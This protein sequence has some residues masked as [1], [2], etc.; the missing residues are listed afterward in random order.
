MASTIVKSPP[1][2]PETSFA[3]I[4]REQTAYADH[5][6]PDAIG[7]RINGWFDRLMIQTGWGVLP[8]AILALCLICGVALGGAAFVWKENFL[9]AALGALIGFVLPMGIAVVA[10]NRRQ[11]KINDQ[12][13]GMIDE[14][15]RAARTGRSLE[16]CLDMVAK[17]TPDPLGSEMSL[18]TKA[19]KL[20]LPVQ[21]AMT[22]LPER[23]GVVGTSILTTALAVHSQTGGD[24][25]HVLERLSRTLR[26]RQELLGRLRAATTASRLTAFLMVILPP[27]ILGFF[28]FRDPEYFRNLMN[29]TWGRFTTLLA[30]GLMI[31]GS[32]WVLRILSSSR[33]L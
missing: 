25:I 10:R 26:D 24:L 29:S 4:L 30:T 16:S 28:L 15:A 27:I 18:C 6:H 17:D 8:G 19:M 1:L 20:G 3:G 23:T 14:L 33:K 11:K 31:V 32:I 22:R 5:A 12:L 2:P 21:E 13:P 7:T 9:I